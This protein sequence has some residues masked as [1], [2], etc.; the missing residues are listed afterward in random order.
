MNSVE[1]LA[2]I[3]EQQRAMRA[4]MAEIQ[5][6]QRE[7]RQEMERISGQLSLLTEMLRTL[8]DAVSAAMADP[9]DAGGADQPHPMVQRALERASDKTAEWLATEEGQEAMGMRQD[10]IDDPQGWFREARARLI[11]ERMDSD[12]AR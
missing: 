5:Q 1:T 11:A 3:V 8:F 9:E 10:F 4:D 2:E 6:E 12:G 7:I